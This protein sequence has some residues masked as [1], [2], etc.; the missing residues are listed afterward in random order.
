MK[1]DADSKGMACGGYLASNAWGSSR[2]RFT[3]SYQLM[4]IGMPV[5]KKAR[6]LAIAVTS[7]ILRRIATV[8]G[9]ASWPTRRV[10]A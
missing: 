8:V 4:N 6:Y 10:T 2:A 3:I 1:A 9:A 5:Q 7:Y